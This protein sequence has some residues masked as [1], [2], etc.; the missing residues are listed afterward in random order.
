LPISTGAQTIGST[1]KQGNSVQ[2]STITKEGAMK[3]TYFANH[4]VDNP[5]TEK[6]FNVK[7]DKTVS[8]VSVTPPTNHSGN[9]T[10]KFS[11]SMDKATLMQNPNA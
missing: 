9:V 5:E 3:I 11:E 8:T 4:N 6:T 7:L 2:I 1:T 10:V